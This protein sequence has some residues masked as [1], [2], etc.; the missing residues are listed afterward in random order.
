MPDTLIRFEQIK[1]NCFIGFKIK[2]PT[3]SAKHGAKTGEE[4]KAKSK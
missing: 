4:L 1:L 3:S 2:S